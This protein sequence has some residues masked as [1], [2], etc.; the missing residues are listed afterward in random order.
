MFAF[1][2]LKREH[3]SRLLC[4]LA[5]EKLSCAAAAITVLS[6]SLP[7]L[8]CC[9]RC[10]YVWCSAKWFLG[11]PGAA[12]EEQWLWDALWDGGRRCEA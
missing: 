8:L 12:G 11:T 1:G 9:H 2:C 4:R 6:N 3:L 5:V 10:L 7:A